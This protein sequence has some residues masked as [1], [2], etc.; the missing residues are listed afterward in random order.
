MRGSFLAVVEKKKACNG[1]NCMRDDLVGKHQ[2]KAKQ[3]HKSFCDFLEKFL[4]VQ[5]NLK[6]LS[7]DNITNHVY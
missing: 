4:Q 2:S 5:I 1:K 6:F 3:K 7:E